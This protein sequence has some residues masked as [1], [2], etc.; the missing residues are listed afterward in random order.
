MPLRVNRFQRLAHF[1]EQ[2]FPPVQLLDGLIF[3]R[4]SLRQFQL[5]FEG[6]SGAAL[7]QIS[8][9][10]GLSGSFSQRYRRVS[11]FF[12]TL[13]HAMSIPDEME[14]VRTQR[15]RQGHFLH[16]ARIPNALSLA[17]STRWTPCL[18]TSKSRQPQVVLSRCSCAD[19]LSTRKERPSTRVKQGLCP[20]KISSVS[21]NT[22]MD[23]CKLC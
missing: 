16:P 23:K 15:D 18:A 5:H 1:V 3:L 12:K 7:G 17:T 20:W 10:F 13:A 19:R 14:Q 8:L 2:P 22:G 6:R 11:A 4:F 21:P 9:L